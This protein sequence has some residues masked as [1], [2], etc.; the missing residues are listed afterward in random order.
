MPS[1]VLIVDDERPIAQALSIR[2]RAVG[3]EVR[4]AHDG[5]S[6]VQ[7]AREWHPCVIILDIRMPDIDGFEVSR[8]LRADPE[9]AGVPVIFLSA[10]V[11]E[12]ARHAALAAGA[13][14]FLKKPYDPREVL[15]AVSSALGCAAACGDA[16][17]IR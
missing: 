4:S 1:K 13:S 10:N 15:A 2:L 8:Q 17:S 5:L 11:Q 7:A 14:A 9:L 3:H 12:S 6:G 16:R